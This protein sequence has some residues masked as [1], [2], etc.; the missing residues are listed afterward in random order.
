MRHQTNPLID[1]LEPRNLFATLTPGV[2][3]NTNLNVSSSQKNWTVDLVAGQNVTLAA[4]DLSGSALQ[5]ELILISPAN[6]VLRRSVGENGSFLSVNAPTSGTYRVRVRDVGRDHFGSVKVNA[7]F[8]APTI[9]DS[10]DAFS[11]ESGRRRAA[12]IDPGDLDTW[13]LTAQQAQFLSVHAAENNAGNAVDIGVLIIGPNGQVVTGAEDE[14]GVKLDIPNASAGNYY[15]VVYEAGAN[16]T[17]R[18]GI[19]F[20]RVPGT[21]YAGDPDTATPL[22]SNVTRSGDMPGGDY[23]IFGINLSAGQAFSATLTK[24]TGSLNPELLLID[25]TGKL[26]KTTSG[27]TSTTLAQSINSTGQW[28]LF[29]RDRD[30]DAGGQYTIRYTA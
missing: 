6:K 30:A 7:F 21:Q 15:A 25:P 18:Y 4:G 24:G 14:E 12:D 29:A 16:D 22:S 1:A 9:T 3:W 13:T 28:W 20:G 2:T 23:D 5:T 26:I 8:Y 19:T 10:D 11:A 27:N 17:S